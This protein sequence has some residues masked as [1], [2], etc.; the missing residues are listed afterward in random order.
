MGVIG[1]EKTMTP[2]NIQ[3]NIQC[4]RYLPLNRIAMHNKMG[5]NKI[6]VNAPD[7]VDK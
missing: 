2:T 7:M 4:N 1:F 6:F 3:K 5:P